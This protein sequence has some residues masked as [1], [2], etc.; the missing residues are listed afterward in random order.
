V[1][2]AV[3][4]KKFNKYFLNWVKSIKP[5]IEEEIINIDGKTVHRS[6]I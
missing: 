4:P 2:S 1:F 6:V 3:N 5:V